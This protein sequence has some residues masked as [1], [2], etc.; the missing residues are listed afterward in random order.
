LGGGG[1]CSRRSCKNKFSILNKWILF[2]LVV[3]SV[4]QIG[5]DVWK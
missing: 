2:L 5:A 3:S 1:V 4:A